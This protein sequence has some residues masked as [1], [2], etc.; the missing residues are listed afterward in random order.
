MVSNGLFV[1]FQDSVEMF[2]ESVECF[3]SK[4]QRGGGKTCFNVLVVFCFLTGFF[5]VE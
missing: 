4:A 2:S 3:S 5:G 1:S